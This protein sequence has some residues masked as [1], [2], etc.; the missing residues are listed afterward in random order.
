M[1]AIFKIKNTNNNSVFDD[2]STRLANTF[3]GCPASATLK[4][5][6]ITPKSSAVFNAKS[7][8]LPCK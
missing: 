6:A 8:S 7:G 4:Y 2:Y 1:N 5:T 3:N